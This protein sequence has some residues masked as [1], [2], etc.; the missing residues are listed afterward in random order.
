MWQMVGRAWQQFSLPG[1]EGDYQLE[2]ELMSGWLISCQRNPQKGTPLTT[3]LINYHS[4]DSSDLKIRTITSW[5]R[6]QVH[7]HLLIRI[8]D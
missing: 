1:E 7:K 5:A 8:Y 3:P 6:G 2:E 4:G